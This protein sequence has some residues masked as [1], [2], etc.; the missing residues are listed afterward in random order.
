MGY[1]SR[2]FGEIRL[3]PPLGWQTIRD[4]R[5]LR[6]SR[7]DTCL[8]IKTDVEEVDTD[9][10]RLSV[11]RGVVIGWRRFDEM[12]VYSVQSE[13]DELSD[14]LRASGSRPEGLLIRVGEEQGDIERYF[15]DAASSRGWRSEKAELRWPDG[16]V[17]D[18]YY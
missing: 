16:S 13:L 9:Q 7:A 12:K 15:F 5:F 1:Y 18:S 6:D 10:G 17:C 8:V 2:G 11:M 4:S 3:E 14:L